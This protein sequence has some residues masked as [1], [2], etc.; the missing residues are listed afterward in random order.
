MVPCHSCHIYGI[1]TSRSKEVW[2][3]LITHQLKMAMQ[4]TKGDSFR[5]EGRFSLCNTAVL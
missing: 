4:V 3:M 5:R 1:P 2:G